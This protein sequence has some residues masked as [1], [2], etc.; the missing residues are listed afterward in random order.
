MK[1]IN[2]TKNKSIHFLSIFNSPKNTRIYALLLFQKYNKF[3]SSSS[4]ILICLF[5]KCELK[6]ELILSLK[7][8]SR[9]LDHLKKLVVDN[10]VVIAFKIVLK[11]DRS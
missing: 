7:F 6:A 2:K 10:S 3:L 4:L 8:F 11:S 1:P 5:N 9:L